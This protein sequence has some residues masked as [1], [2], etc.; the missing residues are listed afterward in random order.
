M[1]ISCSLLAIWAFLL[2]AQQSVDLTYIVST[3][4]QLLYRDYGGVN[5]PCNVYV[6]VEI[7]MVS[8]VQTEF[9]CYLFIVLYELFVVV[10][11]F[12]QLLT[13]A[14]PIKNLFLNRDILICFVD[15]V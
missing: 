13:E 4:F 3:Y 9:A 6:F 12:V 5:I 2:I 15:Y 11:F 14:S 8:T 10:I 1:L 7:M